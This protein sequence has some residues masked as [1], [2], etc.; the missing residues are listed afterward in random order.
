MKGSRRGTLLQFVKG[1]GR[2]IP[3]RKL[4]AAAAV[5]HKDPEA[6]EGDVLGPQAATLEDVPKVRNS[7]EDLTVTFQ[8]E[9]D[10][11][12]LL[13][14]REWMWNPAPSEVAFGWLFKA[15]LGR[16][17]LDVLLMSLFS[18][19]F[20]CLLFLTMGQIVTTPLSLT[21]DHWT[22]VR[23][24]GQNLS[25]EVKRGP[26]QAF[27]SLEWPTFGVGWPPIGTFDLPTIRAVK[28]IVFQEG[29][30]SHPDQQP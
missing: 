15:K 20:V 11:I 9:G 5:G 17:C 27:C 4:L 8:N 7:Q 13:L 26:W 23:A 21:T 28:A 29:L 10:E 3:L 18:I 19:L 30:G 12:L 16:M 1:S 22:D 14:K 25:V 6:A 24:R 2:G